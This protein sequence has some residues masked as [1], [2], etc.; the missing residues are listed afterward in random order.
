MGHTVYLGRCYQGI[1]DITRTKVQGC[2]LLFVIY[3]EQ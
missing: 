3:H 2:Q 1:V